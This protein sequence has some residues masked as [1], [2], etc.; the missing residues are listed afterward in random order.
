MQRGLGPWGDLRGAIAEAAFMVGLERNSDKVKLAAY[1]PLFANVEHTVW[2]PNMLY[3]SADRV[4]ASPSWTVQ[5]LFS[6]N[7][8]AEVL[9]CDV[10]S[11]AKDLMASAMKAADG[12]TVVKLVNYSAGEQS[13]G[14]NLVGSASRTIFTGDGPS[15]HNSLYDLESLAE[16]RDTV[17]LGGGELRLPP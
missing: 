4:F 10:P 2:T 8:G 3:V 17:S 15:A 12:A 11:D 6:E 13:V 14:L 9:R 1:A 5:K 16:R 7:R